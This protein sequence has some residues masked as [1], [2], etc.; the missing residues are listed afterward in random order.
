MKRLALTHLPEENLAVSKLRAILE[1]QL[2]MVQPKLGW[3]QQSL[4]FL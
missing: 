4:V 1:L 3:L 2:Q